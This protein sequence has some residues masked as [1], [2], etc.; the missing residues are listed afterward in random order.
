MKEAIVYRPRHEEKL[1][2]YGTRQQFLHDARQAYQLALALPT[3]RCVFVQSERE[4]EPNDF[5][6]NSRGITCI[7]V[8]EKDSGQAAEED[9]E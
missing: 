2:K 6:T 7:I 5:T 4:N 1:E 9:S 3:P 8:I